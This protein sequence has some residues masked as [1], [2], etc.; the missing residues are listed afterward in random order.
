MRGM[1][2]LPPAPEERA[3]KTRSSGGWNALQGVIF[4]VGALIFVVGLVITGYNYWVYKQIPHLEA[5]QDD[6]DVDLAQIE[7]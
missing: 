2:Q 6:I 4:A 3:T 7:D 1:R 5:S